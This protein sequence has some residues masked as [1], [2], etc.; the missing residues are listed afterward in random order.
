MVGQTAV[1]MWC[2]AFFIW[3]WKYLPSRPARHTLQEGQW[4]LTAGFAQNWS[5]AKAIWLQYRKGLKWYLLAL[6]FAEASAAAITN[7]SS[8][9]FFVEV[10]CQMSPWYVVLTPPFCQS[11]GTINSC[12]Y[13]LVRCCWLE[14]FA[15][16]DLLFSCAA[17]NYSRYD[18]P[19]AV[20]NSFLPP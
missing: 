6:V 4:M 17:G 8:W 12:S 18:I 10:N 3:G 9:V 20:Q 19:L 14:Y 7:I 11:N 1:V 16:W 15:S 13:L 2:V 5:T